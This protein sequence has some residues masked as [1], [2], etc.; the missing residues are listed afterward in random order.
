MNDGGH[1]LL[2]SPVLFS[3]F[4]DSSV[5][6]KADV[7][8]KVLYVYMHFVER[9]GDRLFQDLKSRF[10]EYTGFLN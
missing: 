6:T 10:Y 9:L 1:K 5:S 3:H 8:Y 7:L 2:L 4:S